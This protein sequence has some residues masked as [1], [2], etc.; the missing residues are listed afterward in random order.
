MESFEQ[1]HA[2]RVPRRTVLRG[3]AALGVGMAAA[4][5]AGPARADI[6]SAGGQALQLAHGGHTS[7]RIYVNS[8]DDAVVRQAA[9]ELSSYLGSITSARFDIVAAG[10]PPSNG[11]LIVVGRN[12]PVA[13]RA[14]T[15]DYDLLS[16]DGFALR[17]I[18]ES[19]LIAGASSRGTLYG[20]YWFLDRLLGVRWFAADY[21]VIPDAPDLAVPAQLLNGDHVPRFRFRMLEAGD[22]ND[23]AYRQHNMLNGLRD[24]YWTQ[25]MTP[26]IDTWSHY[27]PEEQPNGYSFQ[28]VVTDQSLWYGGQ[29]KAMDPATRTAATNRLIELMQ[30]RIAAGYG[31]SAAFYQQD[32]GWTPDPD[33]QAFAD[34]H[35]GALSAPII[36]MVNEIASRVAA[37]IPGARLE[38]QAYQFSLEPPAGMTVDDNVVMTVAPIFADFGHSLFA[39]DNAGTGQAIRT[40]CALAKNVVLWDYLT[41]YADY[42]QPF[43]DWW[44]MGEGIKTLATLPSA[45]GYFGEGAWNAS[46]T[47]FTQ[48]RVWVIS[49]LLWDPSLDTDGLIREFVSG[50]YGPAGR[51]IYRYMQ[52]MYQSV[53]DTST[54]LTESVDETAPYL[55]FDAMRQ[56]DELFDQA[57]SAVGKNSALLNHVRALRLGVDYVILVRTG[58]FKRDAAA[59]GIDWDP[60]TA[61]RLSRFASE[62]GTSGLTQFSEGGGTPQDLLARVSVLATISEIV[63]AP[64]AA[65]AGLPASDWAD[66]QE[67]S[68]KLYAPVTTIIQDSAASNQYTVRMPGSRTDWGVQV[69]LGDLPKDGTWKIYM[70]VRADTGSAS[71]TANAIQGGVY[72]PFGN[73]INVPVSELSD[74]EYHEI[75]LPGT[76]AN[77]PSLTAYVAPPGSPDIAYVY[78]DRIFAIK[79]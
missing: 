18:G 28:E 32:Q 13:A 6:T 25:P 21:T 37:V 41:T 77:D 40:W 78:V 22:A 63:P 68:L 60:G 7:Y 14:R 75:A 54:T 39:D 44:A 3:G 69:P 79:A 59:A 35:G 26:G 2:G 20:A 9:S 76:Y 31:A 50:Y 53:L 27:W 33:S 70:S 67:D 4:A 64:P 51:Y 45:Q 73:V 61:S 72:P 11:N 65:A 49:R 74:G 24:Q 57:E 58:Q 66:Y 23:A 30:G 56:A 62:L 36:D 34:A 8:G 16:D 42:I 5:A 48:L 46:G 38:T 15:I 10:Q 19:V 12:N 43:P 52:V 1:E 47:E 29:L 17:T 55:T 71:P